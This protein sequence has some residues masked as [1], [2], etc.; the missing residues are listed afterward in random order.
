MSVSNAQQTVGRMAH[1]IPNRAGVGL[2]TQHAQEI[3]A[4]R[5]D[6]G[7]VEVTRRDVEKEGGR[8]DEARV[9]RLRYLEGTP[10]SSTRYIDTGWAIAAYERTK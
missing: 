6:L 9:N 4:E 3:L 2:K 10:K 7:W 8:L 5:A 1:A